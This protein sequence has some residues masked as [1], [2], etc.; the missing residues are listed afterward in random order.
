MKVQ[1]AMYVCQYKY[2]SLSLE[3]EICKISK[4]VKNDFWWQWWLL[5]SNPTRLKKTT[6]LKIIS[7]KQTTLITKTLNIWPS[8][9]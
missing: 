6:A 1:V 4:H 8:K 7:K 9:W 2:F 3:Y 5:T